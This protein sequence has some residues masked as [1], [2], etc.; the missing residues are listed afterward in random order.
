MAKMYY[1]QEEA[2]EKLGA[3]ALKQYVQ[4]GTLHGYQDGARTMYKAGDVDALA[5]EGVA[6]DTGE[7]ELAPAEA[8]EVS[9]SEADQDQEGPA[10]KED[11][12]ITAEGISIF[13]D[14][15]LEIETADP[16][17]KT[18]IA[19]SLAEQPSE[20]GGGSGSGLLDLTRESDDT[21]LGEVLET[22]DVDQEVA[23]AE[24]AEEAPA[25]PAAVGAAP[26]AEVLAAAPA[27]IDASAGL[28]NGFLIGTCLVSL[29]VGVLAAG[30]V[31]GHVP[32]FVSSLAKNL[33]MVLG[34]AAVVVLIAGGFGYM[35]GKATA[36]RREAL[37]RVP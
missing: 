5:P 15:D 2:A 30:L 31:L 21:S 24:Q 29:L 11:T 13:D 17:A 20:A 22:I 7:L 4:D 6:E 32:A 36:A 18:Q 25:G 16:R 9:L 10:G 3:E 35:M 1:T 23:E 27:V 28:F 19:P 37:R 12:V 34:A 33:P 8:D 14:E 26:A